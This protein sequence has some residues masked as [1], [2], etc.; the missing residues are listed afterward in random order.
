MSE[1]N[2][3]LAAAYEQ[4]APPRN[5]LL[6]MRAYH[7]TMRDRLAAWLMGDERA[8]V[9]KSRF[10]EGLIGS[11][12]MGTTGPGVVDATPLGIPMGLQDAIRAGDPNAVA[13]AI[14][15]GGGVANKAGQKVAKEAAGEVKQ[16]IRA[17]HGSP[18]DFDRFDMSKIGTG[19][20]AQA[21][22]H[23]LY[24]ADSPEVAESYR[25]ALTSKPAD[26]VGSFI[27]SKIKYGDKIVTPPTAKYLAEQGYPNDAETV[28]LVDRIIRG[29]QKSGD[30][31]VTYSADALSSFRLLEGRLKPPG[32]LYEVN[33]KANPDDF[34]DWDKPLSQ[35]PKAQEAF[36][37]VKLPPQAM[38]DLGGDASLIYRAEMPK[39]AYDTL[40]SLSGIGNVRGASQALRQA[41]IPG[42]KYLDQGSRAAGEGSRNYVVFDDKLIDI[43]RK[44]GIAAVA[45]ALGMSESDLVAKMNEGQR[46]Q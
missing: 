24:F 45:T 33:I 13:L 6:E 3:L 21:Y 27:E 4:A 18:H 38:D 20:G 39:D 10:V 42:I 40:A 28:S 43:V 25:K 1:R 22:G 8:S 29:G 35:Q 46:Q 31:S 37:K 19:E 23:G 2:R 30:G 16:G 9:E 5:R 12:G 44:Y 14:M 11:R 26:V 17:Y 41:G 15:P 32:R 7:P 36:R 34:L